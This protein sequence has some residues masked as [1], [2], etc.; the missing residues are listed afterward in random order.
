MAVNDVLNQ[1]QLLIQ[2]AAPRLI[3]VSDQPKD[4]IPFLPGERYTAKVQEEIAHG[5]FLVLIRDQKLDLN[6]PRNTQAGQNIE[7]RFVSATP[8]LTFVLADELPQA[9]PQQAA[10][11]LSDG[12]RY[13]SALLDRVKNL[14]ASQGGP[15]QAAQAQQT[16]KPLFDGAPPSAPQFAA[17]LK[18]T[19]AQSGLFYESHQAQWVAGEKPLTELL[20]EPQAKLSEP[21][22]FVAAS[23]ATSAL[24]QPPK[25]EAAHL[26]SLP[27]VASL[28]DNGQEPVHPQTAPLVQQQLDAL[29]MR[30]LIWQGQVWQ[31]QEMRWQIDERAAHEGET[32]PMREW[33]TRLDLQLPMLGE[34]NAVLK[35][36]PQGGVSIALTAHTAES[37]HALQAAGTLL[38]QSMG[39]SGL[40]LVKLE[41]QNDGS[42]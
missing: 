39:R 26:T 25:I 30:Q 2:G 23:P 31:G 37:A 29:D 20:R 27:A 36:S 10:V 14:A 13:L 9:V 21:R 28:Q 32:D 40:Q 17:L 19:V 15:A 22:A 38:N 3:E 7:L 6:L 35:I 1:L 33:Q 5:R 4:L 42:A 34:V 8:R 12:A 24:G 41:V 18:A 16:A 11:N